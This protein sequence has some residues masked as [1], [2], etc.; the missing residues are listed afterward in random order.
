LLAIAAPSRSARS[1][2]Q[3]ICGW[4]RSPTPQSMLRCSYTKIATGLADGTFSDWR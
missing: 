1:L 3:A 4:T 2:A